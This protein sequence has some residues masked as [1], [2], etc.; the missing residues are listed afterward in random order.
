MPL[1]DN[2]KRPLKKFVYN[3]V[4]DFIGSLVSRRSVEVSLDD[5]CD[6]LLQESFDSRNGEIRGPFQAQFLRDFE[7]HRAGTRFIDRGD[8][9]R[10]AFSVCVDFF[11][12]EGVSH[13]ASKR[14][15]GAITLACLNLP[16]NIRYNR[17]N[18][19]LAGVIPGP[20]E[21]NYVEISNYLAPLVD[22][23][24]VLWN[25]GVRFSQ[26]ASTPYGRL[27]RA[28]I[29]ILVCDLPA[30]RKVAGLLSHSSNNFVCSHCTCPKQ[31][32]WDVDQIFARRETAV[33]RE[34]ATEWR[35]APTARRKTI[36]KQYGV[37]WSEFWRLPYWDPSRQ[38]VVDPMHCLL[39]GLVHSHFTTILPLSDKSVSEPPPENP[40]YT[41]EFLEVPS[42]EEDPD[43]PIYQGNGK[44]AMSDSEIQRVSDIHAMLLAPIHN[45]SLEKFIQLRD[46]LE[47][48]PRTSLL[49]VWSSLGLP[50]STLAHPDDIRG[51]QPRN[52]TKKI[53]YAGALARW[54]RIVFFSFPID[55]A[56]IYTSTT[57]LRAT[58][59]FECAIHSVDHQ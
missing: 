18:M 48:K 19:Y 54:V 11:N 15:I 59:C 53:Q 43:N 33:L 21:P 41:Y 28:A 9:L 17:E 52:E 32:I 25:T 10:L 45:P 44:S 7:G 22:E 31:K 42:R 40:A 20:K 5:A 39:L 38:L 47:R 55:Q 2:K 49:F 58:S 6:E 29:A 34:Q 51:G 23:F 4:L 56:L 35:V 36:E 57:A 26:T 46:S 3:S 16:E 14:S 24:L 30:V 8:E 1:L 50:I 13:G 27:V 37:R 12:V